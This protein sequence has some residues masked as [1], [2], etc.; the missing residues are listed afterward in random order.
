MSD[1]E[2][3]FE[4]DDEQQ[5]KGQEIANVQEAAYSAL[6]LRGVMST[7]DGRHFMWE[8]L[9]QCGIYQDSFNADPHVHAHR[10]GMTSVGLILMKRILE[11]CPGEHERMYTEHKYKEPE[12][13]AGISR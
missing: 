12:S 6:C 3:P 13:G 11:E 1:N 4:V 5:K 9:A 8:V 10:A 2:K 7:I